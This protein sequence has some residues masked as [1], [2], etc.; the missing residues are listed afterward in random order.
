MIEKAKTIFNLY[1]P[2]PLLIVI[3]GPSG[4]GKD[5]VL[6]RMKDKDLPFHFVVTATTRAPRSDEQDGVDYIFITHEKFTSMIETGELIEYAIGDAG[7]NPLGWMGPG[8]G[9]TGGV[10]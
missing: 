7:G 2:E 1:K 3:S 5:A 10:E 4:V 6:Q 8:G 9:E